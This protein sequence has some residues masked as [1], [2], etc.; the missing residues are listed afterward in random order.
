MGDD[1]EIFKL[2]TELFNRWDVGSCK[3]ANFF[4]KH[5]LNID[6][7]LTTYKRHTSI[8]NPHSHRRGV[9]SPLKTL[10]S[11]EVVEGSHWKIALGANNWQRPPMIIYKSQRNIL[12]IIFNIIFIIFKLKSTH[13][14]ESLECCKVIILVIFAPFGFS[15]RGDERL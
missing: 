6:E 7:C 10:L 3:D 9:Y 13:C 4:I 14:S 2:S 11:A 8:K 1:S 5:G 15:A 12:I